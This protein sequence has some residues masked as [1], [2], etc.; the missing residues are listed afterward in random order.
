MKKRG[1]K[2]LTLAKET[3]HHLE[4]KRLQGAAGGTGESVCYCITQLC[5]TLDYT[6]C[7]TCDTGCTNCEG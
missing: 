2:R 5:I 7:N 3:L 6:N 4:D 1:L